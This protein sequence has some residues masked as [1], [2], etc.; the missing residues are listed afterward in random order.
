MLEA[1]GVIVYTAHRGATLRLMTSDDA[2]DLFMLRAET[3]GLATRL[4]VMRIDT[5]TIKALQSTH[6]AMKAELHGAH[7]TPNLLQLNR[8][9]HFMIYDAGSARHLVADPFSVVASPA[10]RSDLV[11]RL[12]SRRVGDRP[13]GDPPRDRGG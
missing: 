4:S 3:E 9:F 7:S 10:R 6:E 11:D 13:R 12:G 8:D 5:E 1:D 2:D